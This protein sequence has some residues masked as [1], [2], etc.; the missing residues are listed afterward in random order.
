VSACTLFL[1][2]TDATINPF[3]RLQ[4][5][6]YKALSPVHSI[7]PISLFS[8]TLFFI[9]CASVYPSALNNI[10][11][12]TLIILCTC[13]FQRDPKS[14]AGV[15]ESPRKHRVMAVL[16][17]TSFSAFSIPFGAKGVLLNFGKLDK[18]VQVAKRE[19]LC[20]LGESEGLSEMYSLLSSKSEKG[21][22]SIYFKGHCW[23]TVKMKHR[24]S[25]SCGKT[26]V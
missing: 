13:K 21:T 14:S 12:L 9:S 3:N 22:P 18:W 17:P 20:S 26:W 11:M 5:L 15:T 2:C 4:F 6:C 16:F 19:C 25:F 1:Q 23:E 8:R 24:F 7:K 10:C